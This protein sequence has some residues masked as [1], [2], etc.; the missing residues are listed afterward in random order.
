SLKAGACLSE[1]ITRVSLREEH[2]GR[3]ASRGGFEPKP[4]SMQ[5]LFPPGHLAHLV[6]D[7]GL[8]CEHGVL[9][10]L[11]NALERLLHLLPC[12]HQ[13]QKDLE[14]LPAGALR[15]Q[16]KAQGVAHQGRLGAEGDVRAHQDPAAPVGR[17]KPYPY[18]RQRFGD[19]DPVQQGRVE[20]LHEQ[21]GGRV[22][23]GP[24]RE[25]HA[26]GA[27]RQQ[28]PGQSH[29]AV[30]VDP[31]SAVIRVARVEHDQLGAQL[32]VEDICGGQKV[33]GQ[34]WTSTGR[35]SAV[36][37]AGD[38][39]GGTVAV[40]VE[41]G[42]VVVVVLGHRRARQKHLPGGKNDGG[43]FPGN[44]CGEVDH[45]DLF[46]LVKHCSF[47]GLGADQSSTGQQFSQDAGLKL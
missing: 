16:D 23:D 46:D 41:H 18:L 45:L 11:V 10:A 25:Q 30:S 17:V 34:S 39:A 21:L 2:C 1:A 29:H 14:S 8:G 19:L 13:V 28:S 26:L 42:E 7:R 40:G 6:L 33:L 4:N 5:Q 43:K 20:S 36:D 37:G 3:Q 38:V 27:G 22:R 12:T 32:Q 47:R 15:L 24:Q 44:M 35:P 9:A 31:P